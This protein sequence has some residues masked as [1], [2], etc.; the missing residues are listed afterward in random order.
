RELG[1]TI[2]AIHDVVR[3]LASWLP[4]V[5]H[6]GEVHEKVVGQ[7]A[8]AVRK[9]AVAG[10][11]IVCTQHSH[12]TEQNR[13][14]RRGQTHQ[15]G[16]IQEQLLR[17]DHIVLLLPITESIRHW[18]KR[19]KGFS[20]GHFVRS[21]APTFQER[22]V[23]VVTSGFS[24]HFDPQITTQYDHVSNAGTGVGGDLFVHTE[25]FGKAGR[26]VTFPVFLWGQT[27]AGT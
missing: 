15:L 24:R 26:L 16:A 27:D 22:Y 13:H 11:T 19:L 5:R 17:L 7:L 6:V 9:H 18:L 14:F 1:I 12:T 3:V 25:H 20:V 10:S 2:L 8:N 21:V 4:T 23:H